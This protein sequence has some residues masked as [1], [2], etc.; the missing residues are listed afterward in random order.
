MS[1]HDSEPLVGAAE[2]HNEHL[3]PER[4]GEE[5]RHALLAAQRRFLEQEL[6]DRRHRERQRLQ[7]IH[8]IRP[9]PRP[10]PGAPEAAPPPPYT[11]A[12]QI[13]QQLR[14]ENLKL[15]QN[16]LAHQKNAAVHKKEMDQLSRHFWVLVIGVIV[17]NLI[18]Y[19]YWVRVF[20]SFTKLG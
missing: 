15:K 10:R 17:S 14:Q 12:E 11:A 2:S 7:Q 18:V 1:D 20:H 19:Y 8:S 16:N 5:Q 9:R 6:G 13:I 4:L 3:V